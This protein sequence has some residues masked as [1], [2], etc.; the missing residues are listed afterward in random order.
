MFLI[1]EP[2]EELLYLF[3]K[4]LAT[5]ARDNVTLQK[6]LSA[7]VIKRE[8]LPRKQHFLL[9]HDDNISALAVSRSGKY[10]A[11]GQSTHMGFPADV[12]I[13]DYETN[14]EKHRLSLHKGAQNVS[15][16]ATT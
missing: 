11:S 14:K 7:A 2:N 15:F 13:W 16:V 6:C 10:I 8:I 12:I 4:F 9:G 1:F 3:L 5:K